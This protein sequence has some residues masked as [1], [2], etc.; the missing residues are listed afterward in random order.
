MNLLQAKN[1]CVVTQRFDTAYQTQRGP[2]LA[3]GAQARLERHSMNLLQAKNRCVVTQRFDTAYQT[4]R[5]PRFAGGAQA[6][7]ERPSK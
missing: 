6:R 3:G 1:R 7:L 4:Q 2:R 5:G